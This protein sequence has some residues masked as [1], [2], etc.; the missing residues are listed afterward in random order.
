MDKPKVIFTVFA[1]RKENL[2]ILLKYTD[3]LYKSGNI[4]EV[5]LWNYTRNKMDEEWLKSK[6]VKE[7]EYV[8]VMNVKN[9][10]K[11]G[12]YYSYY[13]EEKYP[14]NVIIKSDDDIVFI[15]VEEFPK[16][17]ERRCKEEESILGFPSIINNVRAG[18]YQQNERILPESIEKMEMS[19][20]SNEMEYRR[21]GQRTWGSGVYAARLH[22]FFLKDVDGWI[23]KSKEIKPWYVKHKIG[24]RFSINFFAILSKHLYVYKELVDM[25]KKNNDDENHITVEITKKY[26]KEHYVDMHFTVSHLAFFPQRSDRRLFNENEFQKRYLELATEYLKK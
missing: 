1:G 20:L 6:E 22:D 26:G 24:L 25:L 9:K 13:T 11:W 12:E 2:R 3:V 10:N 23:K 19:T 16:F 5:H 17:I 15:D 8:E 18:I 4:N 14:N 21:L 7:R